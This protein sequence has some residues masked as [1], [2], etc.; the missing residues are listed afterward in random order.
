MTFPFVSETGATVNL[1]DRASPRLL[2]AGTDSSSL[3]ACGCLLAARCR[4]FSYFLGLAEA[5][6]AGNG[7]LGWLIGGN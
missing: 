4:R 3:E 5:F 1:I 7:A 6:F 2:V